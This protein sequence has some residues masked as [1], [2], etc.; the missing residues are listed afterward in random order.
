MIVLDMT[1]MLLGLSVVVDTY[2]QEVSGVVSHLSWILFTLDLVDGRIGI[3]AK[4]QL[5]DDSG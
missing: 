5:D 4:L 2:E 3:L 1:G